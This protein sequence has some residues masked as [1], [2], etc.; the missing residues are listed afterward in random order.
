M[1][2]AFGTN[3]GVIRCAL[4]RR[5]RSSVLVLCFESSVRVTSRRLD[6]VIIC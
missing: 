3:I 2:S 5:V 6:F 4:F 1:F